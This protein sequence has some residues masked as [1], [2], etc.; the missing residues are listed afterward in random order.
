MTLTITL[1]VLLALACAYIAFLHTGKIKDADND[2][3]PDTIEAATE[4]AVKEAEARLATVKKELSDVTKAISEVG[5]QIGDVPKAVAG[6]K[7][8]GPKA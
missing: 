4:K 7:R 8:T 1:C 5:K 3:I 2:F 6:K